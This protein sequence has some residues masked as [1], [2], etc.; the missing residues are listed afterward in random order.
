MSTTTADCC[1]VQNNFFICYDCLQQ[2]QMKTVLFIAFLPQKP[3][4][5]VVFPVCFVPNRVKNRFEIGL[6][7]KEK[8]ILVQ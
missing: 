4:F 2:L 8:H 5:H 3:R 7:I 1:N 6:K